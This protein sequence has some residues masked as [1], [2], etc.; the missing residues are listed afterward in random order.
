MNNKHAKSI[1][2]YFFKYCQ[3]VFIK[4]NFVYYKLWYINNE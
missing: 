2:V 4:S 3:K 1:Y